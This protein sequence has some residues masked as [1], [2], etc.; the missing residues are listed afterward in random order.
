M[1]KMH[2]TVYIKDCRFQH[3]VAILIHIKKHSS[4]P[5]H[6]KLKDPKANPSYFA[7]LDSFL[8]QGVQDVV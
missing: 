5:G 6:L 8:H 4:L 7:V 2:L 1:R 3:K